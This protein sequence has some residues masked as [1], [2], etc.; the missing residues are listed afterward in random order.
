MGFRQKGKDLKFQPVG[1]FVCN[2]VFGARDACLDG[3]G[4]AYIPKIVAE[5]HIQNGK[6]ISV[7]EP[8]CPTH[9]GLHLFYPR[10]HRHSMPLSLFVEEMKVK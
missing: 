7:L 9:L 1:Q 4:L 3:I 6:L 2:N 8:F 10:H 5:E